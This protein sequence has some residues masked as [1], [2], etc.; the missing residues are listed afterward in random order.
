[1]PK[2]PQDAEEFDLSY[3]SC[4][5]KMKR[6]THPMTILEFREE[7]EYRNMTYK[8]RCFCEAYI[9]QQGNLTGAGE[10]GYP[11]SKAP[12]PMG[13]EAFKSLQ[14][15][16]ALMCYYHNDTPE[17]FLRQIFRHIRRGRITE[18]TY[19]TLR[20]YAEIKGWSH[21][22]VQSARRKEDA[23]RLLESFSEPDETLD[24]NG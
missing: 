9:Q 4:V 23:K 18:L 2:L 16:T 24:S 11:G 13:N 12:G 15:L 20:L 7:P 14:V 6:E 21:G 19:K 10:E 17:F 22:P 3:S 5:S 8:Q 1:M